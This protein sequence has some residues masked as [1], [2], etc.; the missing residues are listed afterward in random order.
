MADDITRELWTKWGFICAMGGVTTVCRQP[1]GAVLD[2]QETREL[3]IEVLGEV[4]AVGRA[5]G[6]ALAADY[7][8][9]RLRF[10]ERFEPS[11][12]SSMQR[13][14]ER[15][16]P[17]EIDALN[18]RVTDYG[19]ELGIATS[20]NAFIRAALLPAHRVALASRSRAR[21]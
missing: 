21:S 14:A 16:R 5:R 9:G 12:K 8:V 13:D 1:L 6:V 2:T 7:V 15:S 10:A 19:A 11:A 18:G 17:L 3:F 4:E 20:A